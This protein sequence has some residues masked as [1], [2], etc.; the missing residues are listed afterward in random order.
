MEGEIKGKHMSL[1]PV[2]G[3]HLVHFREEQ[4]RARCLGS[5]QLQRIDDSSRCRGYRPS[6]E[7]KH[8]L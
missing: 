7:Q 8:S 1:M 4:E 3:V 5:D 6:H 2:K